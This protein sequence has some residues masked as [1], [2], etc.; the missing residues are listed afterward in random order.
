MPSGVNFRRAVERTGRS[1]LQPHGFNLSPG[2]DSGI[3]AY[4]RP[5]RGDF[6]Q[7]IGAYT[8]RG[9]AFGVDVGLV[10][11]GLDFGYALPWESGMWKQTGLRQQLGLLDPEPPDDRVY[12]YSDQKSLEAEL[13]RVFQLALRLGPPVWERFGRRLLEETR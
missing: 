4:L 7:G 8:I 10:R 6:L 5:W 13:E 1:V 2:K 3:L 12:H 9:A 11:K